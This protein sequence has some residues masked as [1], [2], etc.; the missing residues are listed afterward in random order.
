MIPISLTS[1]PFCQS[2]LTLVQ[3]PIEPTVKSPLTEEVQD[4]HPAN[5]TLGG[6]GQVE[7]STH[8]GDGPAALDL[9]KA[10]LRN[11]DTFGDVAD[12]YG[13]HDGDTSSVMEMDFASR[14]CGGNG[15]ILA[16]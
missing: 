7:F 12:V 13:L 10:S 3:A 2:D 9:E 14:W 5:L 8:T 11:L 16:I 1:S 15:L 4:F 6:V